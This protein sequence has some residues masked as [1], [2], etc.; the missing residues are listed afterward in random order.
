MISMSS[1][2]AYEGFAEGVISAYGPQRERHT[3][4]ATLVTGNEKKTSLEL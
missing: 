4:G 3:Q 2:R 1:A